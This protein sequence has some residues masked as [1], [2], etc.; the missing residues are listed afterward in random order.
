MLKKRYAKS[1]DEIA[2]LPIQGFSKAEKEVVAGTVLLVAR[3]NSMSLLGVQ[4]NQSTVERGAG[5]GSE[6]NEDAGK[7][8]DKSSEETIER[9]NDLPGSKPYKL[10]NLSLNHSPTTRS[11]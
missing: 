3:Q 10:Y 8:R 11:A 5:G 4:S 1:V 2:E 7:K 9:A 6:G